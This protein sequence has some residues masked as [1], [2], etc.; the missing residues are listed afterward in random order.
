[1]F[2]QFYVCWNEWKQTDIFS[3]NAPTNVDLD[4]IAHFFLNLQP[5]RRVVCYIESYFIFYVEVLD[6]LHW[7]TWHEQ[8]L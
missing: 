4:T 5:W 1:M 3:L 8:Y 7:Q 2:T 6:F